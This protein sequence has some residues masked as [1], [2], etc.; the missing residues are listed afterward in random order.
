MRITGRLSTT[1]SV[2]RVLA[3]VSIVSAHA[4]F[5]SQTPQAFVSFY[6]KLGTVGVAAYFMISG[7]LY[8]PK[9]YAGF[10]KMLKNK[11]RS[12]GIPWLVLG[13]VVYLYN[14]FGNKSFSAAAYLE[15]M[16]GKNSYLYFLTML[17]FCFVVCYFVNSKLVLL[18]FAALSVLSLELTAFGVLQ[19]VIAALHI[20]NYLNIFN[21]LGFFAFGRLVQTINADRIFQFLKTTR[22]AIFGAATYPAL[23]NR[24]FKKVSNDSFSVYLI[25]L[26]VISLLNKACFKLFSLFPPLQLIQNLLVIAV[27]VLLIELALLLAR[28][29]KL[30]RL[31]GAV[32]AVKAQQAVA[33]NKNQ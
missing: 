4:L 17:L 21:W 5:V 30:N 26:M 27:S 23:N 11:A 2:A 28:A 9:N 18:A 20:T 31:A 7:F 24:V 8:F 22:V 13:S 19:P 10:G 32:F 15:F 3:L 14:A 25:H 29:L 12:I 16:L 33:P 1:I 6:S